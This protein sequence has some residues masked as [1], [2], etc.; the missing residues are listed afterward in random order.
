[1]AGSIWAP[2]D[3]SGLRMTTWQ[4]G[5]P[6]SYTHLDGGASWELV[7]T[8]QDMWTNDIQINPGNDLIVLAATQHGLYR[9][10]DG[11][12]TWNRLLNEPSYDIEWKPNDPSVAF[13][14]RNDPAA[15]I[16]RFYK[17]TDAGL[18]WELKDNGWFFSDSEG[19][20]DGGARLAVTKADPNRIYAVLIGE[21][22]TCLLYT[23]RCV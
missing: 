4:N 23:S 1:M 9:S 13:L 2:I 6:V 14:V 7:L 15:G 12:T 11:G 8:D 21:A 18:N 3:L 20:N 17:S 10:E 16:C 22:K 19:R 5:C